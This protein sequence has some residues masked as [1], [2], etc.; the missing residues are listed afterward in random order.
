[1]ERITSPL[2]DE[3]TQV[4][5]HDRALRDDSWDWL[6]LVRCDHCAEDQVYPTQVPSRLYPAYLL[7]CMTKR[8][9]RANNLPTCWE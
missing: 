6:L 4:S 1:M 9:N 2:M 7:L 3:K 8:E 5:G